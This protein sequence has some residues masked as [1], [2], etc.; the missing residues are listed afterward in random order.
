MHRSFR[1]RICSSC[2]EDY[3][4]Y[5]SSQV[6]DIRNAEVAGRSQD[7]ARG[8]RA[9][10]GSSSYG[11]QKRP[12]RDSKTGEVYWGPE[13][14]A[15]AWA[16]FAKEKF[17]ATPR[18][19]CRGDMPDLG[20]SSSR[21]DDVP[22]DEHLEECLKALSSSKAAGRDGI[23]VEVYKASLA[24]KRELFAMVKRIWKQ[25]EVPEEMVLGIF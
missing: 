22:K 10:R 20:P 17:S 16:E 11:S 25:E 4:T 7:I 13:E 21:E 6:S 24:A 12:S 14:L 8:V 5:I 15:A 3:R 19:A 1:K 2:R 18:E 23:P 9:L